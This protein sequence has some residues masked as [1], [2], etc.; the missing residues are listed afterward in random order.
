METAL[1]NADNLTGQQDF[2]PLNGTD[3]VEFYVGNAKQAAHYYKTAFG[4]QP[5]AYAGPE[6]GV[7]DRV[8]YVLVQNKLRFVLTTSLLPDT[9]IARHVAKHGDGV[10]VLA[11]WVD[12]ARSAYEETV[13]RGA[14]PYLEPVV[15][16]DEFGEVVRSG[17]HTYGDTVHL[18]VERRNYKGLFMPGYKEW[19]STYQPTETGLLYVDHCVGNVGW[20]EMNTWVEFYERVMG[21]RNLISFDD[22]DISTE[23]S[24]LMS[25]VMSNGNGR[26]KFPINEPAEGKKK[27]QIEEYL[28]FY[29]GPGV[30]HVAIATNDIVHTVTELQNRGVEF[31][32]VPPVY[33]ETLLDRVGKIDEE[34]APLQK[35]GI[36]VDRDDEGYLLQ[37]FTKPIQ[38]RP[39]VFFEIIQRKGAQSFGKGNFK[40]LFESI[41]REQALRGNL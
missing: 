17:I 18:F 23:Y 33:Y 19:K 12:D 15:E 27:S 11:L 7:K 20:N 4:F 32:T 16:K 37:I 30:Q 24:A 2:L 35:L 5:V 14:T 25:K 26:V 6:T 21:F 34:I 29:G 36:L 3:Y 10:K 40:A 28:D 38:D 31:L 8:S 39:T 41:E 1:M 9:E 13:K 22:S